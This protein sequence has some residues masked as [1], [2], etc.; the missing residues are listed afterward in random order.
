LLRLHGVQHACHSLQF[1][2]PRLLYLQ[3]P[4]REPPPE[5]PATPELSSAPRSPDEIQAALSQPPSTVSAAADSSVQTAAAATEHG[6]QGGGASAESDMATALVAERPISPA[7]TAPTSASAR[8]PPRP[9]LHPARAVS[10]GVRVRASPRLAAAAAAAMLSPPPLSL[11]SGRPL[12]AHRRAY[13]LFPSAQLPTLAT[14]AQAIRELPSWAGLQRP[15]HPVHDTISPL[16]AFIPNDGTFFR[17]RS[18][19]VAKKASALGSHVGAGNGSGSGGAQAASVLGGVECRGSLGDAVGH[20][21][22]PGRRTMSVQLP[23]GHQGHEGH[24]HLG[25]VGAG[26]A[27]SAPAA[28]ISAGLPPLGAAA[29]PKLDSGR[30]SAVP[31]PSPQLGE[32]RQ[33]KPGLPTEAEL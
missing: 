33:R 1:F 2:H 8:K 24:G 13:S 25:A 31:P 9:P 11:E 16:A 6:L 28:S 15:R 18:Q 22:L 3:Q 32:L 23:Y 27:G 4:K 14:A 30:S 7:E 12:P 29:A 19:Q 20:A 10:P 21:F 17:S 5:S 26:V